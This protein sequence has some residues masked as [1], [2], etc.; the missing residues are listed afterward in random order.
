MDFQEFLEYAKKKLRESKY[1]MI[2][3]LFLLMTAYLSALC[4]GYDNPY[5]QLIEALFHSETGQKIDVSPEQPAQALL[6][7]RESLYWV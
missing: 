6:F 1:K 7:I 5:E 2:I 3:L 4:L